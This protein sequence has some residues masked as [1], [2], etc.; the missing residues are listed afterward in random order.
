M[1]IKEYNKDELIKRLKTGLPKAGFYLALFYLIF[2]LNARFE[3]YCFI[4]QTIYFL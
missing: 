1:S 4:A 2:F 3:V